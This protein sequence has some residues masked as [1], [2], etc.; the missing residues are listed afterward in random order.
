MYDKK[1]WRRPIPL[2]PGNGG[3]PIFLKFILLFASE[4]IVWVFKG[5]VLTYDIKKIEKN[6]HNALRFLVSVTQNEFDQ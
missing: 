1:L 5:S 6:Y 3:M 4:M 2:F